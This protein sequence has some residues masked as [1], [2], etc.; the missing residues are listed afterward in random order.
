MIYY[1]RDMSSG[2]SFATQLD[3]IDEFMRDKSPIRYQLF[4]KVSESKRE[5][6][7]EWKCEVRL[8]KPQPYLNVAK[9]LENL[10]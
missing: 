6:Q 5:Q 8:G 10:Q 2:R 7:I 1:I 4:A 9:T 3:E